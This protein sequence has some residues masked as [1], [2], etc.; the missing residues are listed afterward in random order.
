[1]PGYTELTAR[2]AWGRTGPL[3]L[4]IVGDNLLHDSHREFQIGGP[5]ESIERSAY[6]QITWRAAGR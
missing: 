1:V 2:F 5:P 3:E 4:A 6:V